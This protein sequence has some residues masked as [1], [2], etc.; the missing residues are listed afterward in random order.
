MR[1][2]SGEPGAGYCFSKSAG[3]NGLARV[4]EPHLTLASQGDVL[5]GL[6]V[7]CMAGGDSY[8]EADNLAVSDKQRPIHVTMGWVQ[9]HCAAVNTGDDSAIAHCS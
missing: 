9:P 7:H 1:A 3:G 5:E 2:N 6:A 4:L 8:S